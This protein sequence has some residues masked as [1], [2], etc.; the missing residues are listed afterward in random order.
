MIWIENRDIGRFWLIIASLG[1]F[2]YTL[3]VIGLPFVDEDYKA[4]VSQFFPPLELALIIPSAIG[5]I[6]FIALVA[7]AYHLVRLSRRA[8][9]TD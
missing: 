4:T 1:F 6:V 5:S 9:K 8:D 7:R 3:W 2:Y